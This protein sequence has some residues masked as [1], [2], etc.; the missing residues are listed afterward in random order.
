[1]SSPFDRHHASPK[2]S[3]FVKKPHGGG[4]PS[5]FLKK[6]EVASAAFTTTLETLTSKDAPHRPHFL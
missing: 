5:A 4:L 1:M 6:P 2:I 3:S